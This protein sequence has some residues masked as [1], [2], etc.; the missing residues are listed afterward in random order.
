MTSR[1]QD[2]SDSCSYFKCRSNRTSRHAH[3]TLSQ[4][5]QTVCCEFIVALQK[6]TW[7][8]LMKITHKEKWISLWPIWP[9]PSTSPANRTIKGA[10]PDFAYCGVFDPEA[11]SL[12]TERREDTDWSELNSE[13]L[14][15]Q[16]LD[17]APHL[18]L[19]TIKNHYCENP[20]ARTGLKRRP[21]M[22]SKQSGMLQEEIILFNDKDQIVIFVIQ[23]KRNMSIPCSSFAQ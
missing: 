21:R 4:A 10:Q 11:L 13:H 9:T 5:K 18:Q 14:R 23:R 20:V 22:L 3:W 6:W 8:L 19:L 17:M 2:A 7:Y 1:S 16:K 12:V 15:L